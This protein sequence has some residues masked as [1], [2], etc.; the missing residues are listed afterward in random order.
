MRRRIVLAVVALLA[1]GGA[2]R[3]SARRRARRQVEAAKRS[4]AAVAAVESALP[5]VPRQLPS[6]ATPPQDDDIVIADAASDPALSFDPQVEPEIPVIMERPSPTAASRGRFLSIPWSPHPDPPP[7]DTTE[8]RLHCTLTA[9][10]ME[11]AR[12]DVRETASQVFVTVLA[13][14]S[15]VAAGG[16]ASAD[17][18]PTGRK[19]EAIATLREPL[20]E[21]ALVPAPHDDA[22]R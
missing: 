20:G 13:R 8:L 16:D 15:P 21:R 3:L 22:P 10:G 5:A 1:A 4:A 14:W 18:P 12:V 17:K 11:L 7:A 6:A 2:V 19:R 9:E